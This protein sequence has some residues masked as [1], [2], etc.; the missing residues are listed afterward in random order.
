MRERNSSPAVGVQHA[1]GFLL[2]DC[3]VC[4]MRLFLHSIT[5]S[6]LVA[7]RCPVLDAAKRSLNFVNHKFWCSAAEPITS[8][9]PRT[10]VKSTNI[11]DLNIITSR[12]ILHL[13]LWASIYHL[14]IQEFVLRYVLLKARY[15]RSWMWM[16]S[17]NFHPEL[18]YLAPIAAHNIK[19]S[20]YAH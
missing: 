1:E 3:A 20:T 4:H 2:P 17:Q 6:R 14:R 5:N 10:F 19:C 16:Q 13:V 8:R 9:T 18:N 15:L 7:C 12:L 11:L